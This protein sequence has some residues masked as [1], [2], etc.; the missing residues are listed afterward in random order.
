MS[1]AEKN[2]SVEQAFLD[3][4]SEEFKGNGIQSRFSFLGLGFYSS[5]FSEKFGDR[6]IAGHGHDAD[7][8]MATLKAAAELVER[9]AVIDFFS[10][11]PEPIQNSNGWAVGFTQKFS[12]EAAIREALERHILIYTFLRSGWSEFLQVDEKETEMGK[13]WFLVSPYTQNGHFAGMVIY[14]DKNFPGI[15]F[16]YVCDRVG[17]E[18]TSLRWKHAIF[19]AVAFVERVKETGGLKDSAGCVYAAC[20]DWLMQPWVNRAWSRELYFYDLPEVTP[21]T[22]SGQLADYGLHYTHVESGDFLPLFLQDD[23]KKS[24]IRAFVEE[25]TGR[26][27]LSLSSERMPIV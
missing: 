13:A 16:G 1:G 20:R 14:Q 15:S 25:I 3:R 23:L 10:R 26:Y 4:F 5:S 11:N 12:E 24:E 19:E 18:G 22:R 6:E 21:K 17:N 27:G 7:P 9:R 8:V 2:S